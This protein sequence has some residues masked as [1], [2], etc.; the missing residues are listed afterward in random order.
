MGLAVLLV[1]SAALREDL[2]VGRVGWF[3]VGNSPVSG[4]LLRSGRRMG[5][6]GN[7]LVP[8]GSVEE[9]RLHLTAVAAL[10]VVLEVWAAVVVALATRV[11]LCAARSAG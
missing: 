5:S 7:S 11:A 6:V 4:V 2:P 9:S 3:G 8:A 1:D 10:L